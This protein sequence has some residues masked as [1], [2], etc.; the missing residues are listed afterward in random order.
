MLDDL[1]Q[2]HRSGRFCGKGDGRRDQQ[3]GSG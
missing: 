1:G 3:Q 2:R